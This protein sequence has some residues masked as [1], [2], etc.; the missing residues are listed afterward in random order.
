[1]A[2][3][4]TLFPARILSRGE[5]YYDNLMI[6]SFDLAQDNEHFAATIQGGVGQYITFQVDF[7]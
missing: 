7:V 5:I 2:N 3:W 6:K 1:M 4:R